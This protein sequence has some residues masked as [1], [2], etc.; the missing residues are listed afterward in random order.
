MERKVKCGPKCVD[1][2]FVPSKGW[3]G[4]K[5]KKNIHTFDSE[6]NELP[7]PI[8]VFHLLTVSFFY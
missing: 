2:L 1:I 7:E 4:G 6:S 3:G 8:P 5:K